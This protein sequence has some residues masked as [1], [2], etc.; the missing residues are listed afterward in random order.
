MT[1]WRSCQRIGFGVG[2][3]GGERSSAASAPGLSPRGIKENWNR[4]EGEHVALRTAELLR[5]YTT[6]SH[7]IG[8]GARVLTGAC[9]CVFVRACMCARECPR[10]A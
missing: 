6:V 1:P 2:S 3:R 7:V 5:G 8:C 4:A 10:F 9:A